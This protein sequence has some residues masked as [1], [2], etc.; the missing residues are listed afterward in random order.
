MPRSPDAPRTRRAFTLVE[1]TVTMAVTSILVVGM[2]AALTMSVRAV[3]RGTDP[4]SKAQDAAR[5]A[6]IIADDA[7]VAKAFTLV[8]NDAI[9]FAVPSR[10]GSGTDLTIRYAL[11][12][13]GQLTRSYNGGSTGVVGAGLS[14]LGFAFTSR[15]GSD[16][17]GDELLLSSFNGSPSA[18]QKSASI[19]S[20]KSASIYIR[21]TMHPG[22]TSWSITRVQVR[23]S[24]GSSG[25]MSV[26]IMLPT[27]SLKPD[28]TLIWS[29][30]LTTSALPASTNWVT[31][32][33]TGVEGLSP[34]KGV[35]IVFE[36]IS[37]TPGVLEY[38]Q[39]SGLPFNS[40]LIIQSG[41][42]Y[43][44][45]NETLDARYFLYGRINISPN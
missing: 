23:L 45:P 34:S 2:G 17:S 22:A 3:D 24:R 7:A 21:P 28:G 44:E 30:E 14:S 5:A 29:T 6:R 36:A 13:E 26:G 20:G 42:V 18:S 16:L 35:C 37:G 43:P 31:L 11:D 32:P 41:G 9:E 38:Q 40:A 1:A 27:S 19:T 12:R 8:S 4:N 15:G 33:V 10:D 25:K 39:G